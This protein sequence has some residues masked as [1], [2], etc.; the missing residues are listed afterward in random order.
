ME[1]GARAELGALGQP[2]WLRSL[3]LSAAVFRAEQEGPTWAPGWP[4]QPSSGMGVHTLG[5]TPVLAQVWQAGGA[6]R[7]VGWGLGVAG[8]ALGEARGEGPV[9][10]TLP[11][12]VSPGSRGR[13]LPACSAGRTMQETRG[14]PASPPL[15]RDR[16]GEDP[17]DRPPPAPRPVGTRGPLLGLQPLWASVCPTWSSARTGLTHACPP[18]PK[19]EGVMRVGCRVTR[20]GGQEPGVWGRLPVGLHC[21]I[22]GVLSLS[23]SPLQ[24]RGG[25]VDSSVPTISGTGWGTLVLL[26]ALPTAPCLSGRGGSTGSGSCPWS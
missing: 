24:E 15:F 4:W 9:I 22:V 19:A 25:S 5:G 6:A 2:R 16:Q 26:C 7:Q 21:S 17:G 20:D 1:G 14:Q 18:G 11:A 23:L 3:C 12:R 8:C 13:E 10:L